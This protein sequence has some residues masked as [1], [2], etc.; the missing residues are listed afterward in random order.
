MDLNV[1]SFLGD[2]VL[3]SSLRVIVSVYFVTHIVPAVKNI[4]LLETLLLY[5]LLQAFS[6]P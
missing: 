1:F 6:S 4:F 3:A 2:P 5:P